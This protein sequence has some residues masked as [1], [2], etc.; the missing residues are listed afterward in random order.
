VCHANYEGEKMVV[1]H[2]AENVGCMDCHGKSYA[3]RDDENNITPPD[4]M[5]P[6]DVIDES[7]EECH[8]THDVAAG[9]VVARWQER[10]LAGK[11]LEAMVCTDCHGE[12]RLKLRTVRWDKRTRELI[13]EGE[14]RPGAAVDDGPKEEGRP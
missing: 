14:P 4:I 5:F 3:H 12:H 13:I 10:A 11:A 6:P 7:C 8:E 9:K 1:V 2:G